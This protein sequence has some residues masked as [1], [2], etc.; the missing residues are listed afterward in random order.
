MIENDYSPRLKSLA[1]DKW[2]MRQDPASLRRVD[3]NDGF[4]SALLG[5]GGS[6][7]VTSRNQNC[8]AII[9]A[10]G[11]AG[12]ATVT[13]V[14]G[15]MG[16]A[17]CGSALAIGIRDGIRVYQNI[18][19]DRTDEAVYVPA[20]F[21]YTGR[22]SV[23]EVAW[24]SQG[25]LWFANTRFSALCTVEQTAPFCMRWRP[26][27]VNIISDDDCCHLNGFAMHNGRP[28]YVTALGASGKPN[29]WR[30]TSPNGGLLMSVEQ[31]I[32][33]AELCLPHSPVVQ[34]SSIFFLESGKGQISKLDL[35]GG[36]VDEICRLP[37]VARGLA[38]DNQAWFV[39]LSR[40][41]DSSGEV[42]DHVRTNIGDI[43]AT[44]IIAID[45]KTG[46]PIGEAVI[47]FISEISSITL[48]TS[49]RSRLS[50][51]T[52]WDLERSW[53]FS[54]DENSKY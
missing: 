48:L 42:A 17:V 4:W 43:D 22:S 14:I 13:S 7:L 11:N 47:P 34:D 5:A 25:Q 26:S 12:M 37:G 27:F 45:S 28:A 2:W 19:N 9:S 3:G 54:I 10:V 1:D 40:V 30:E 35:Q 15:P 16:A 53:F 8:V 31:D 32:L 20:A 38:C 41:R 24:D 6:L 36:K 46:L 49:D 51:P 21:H 18:S 23:H 44:K 52:A 39:G 50:E 33:A 29:G